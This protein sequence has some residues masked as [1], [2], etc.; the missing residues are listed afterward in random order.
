[1]IKN[2]KD[3]KMIILKKEDGNIHS[4]MEKPNLKIWAQ[5]DFN[6]L[7]SGAHVFALT[8]EQNHVDFLFSGTQVYKEYPEI[9]GSTNYGINISGSAV[10]I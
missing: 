6:I 8:P 5:D 3:F 4:V 7:A 10:I 1:M 2:G 9:K